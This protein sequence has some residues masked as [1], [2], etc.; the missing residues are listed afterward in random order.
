MEFEKFI[1]TRG[2]SEPR[3]SILKSGLMSFNTA[4][5]GSF[6]L[7]NFDSVILY[8]SR[9]NRVMGIEPTNDQEES[10]KIKL[11][12]RKNYVWI[13]AKK[14]LDHFKIKY[15]AAKV[16][17]TAGKERGMLTIQVENK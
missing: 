5:V 4:A 11:Q 16:V 9:Q 2:T 6:L 10:A 15:P 7:R 3:I 17:V 13:G 14:F 8:Y 12:K 1:P